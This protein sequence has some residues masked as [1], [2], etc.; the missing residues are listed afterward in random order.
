VPRYEGRLELTWTNK[1]QCLLAHDD[2][3]Y[4]WLSP[5]DYRV[6]EVL[7]LDDVQAVG[8][9]GRRRAADNLL[10]EGDALHALTALAKIPEFRKEYWGKVK[11]AYIDPPFNTQRSW[12]HYDD[13]LEHSVWLAM[14]RDRLGQIKN[15]LSQD[16]SVYVHCDASES[17]YLKAVMDEVFGRSNF[18]TEIIWKRT[19][20]HSDAKTWS[21]VT[22]SIFFYSMSAVI[23]W[24]PP[25]TEHSDEYVDSKY[26]SV[27]DDGRRY[28]LD[29]LTSPNPRPNM[30]YEWKGFAPPAFGWRYA[31]ETMTKLDAEGR[32][33]YPDVKTKRPRLK[34]YL[35]ES[36][37]RLSDNLW[38]DISP[39]N[40]QAKEDS[41]YAT[42]KPEKLLQ[43]IISASSNEGDIVLDCFLGSGT[44]AAVAQKMGRRWIGIEQLAQSLHDHTIPRLTRVIDGTDQSGISKDVSWKGGGGFRVLQVA[45]SMFEAD[46]GMV[47]LSDA[48]TNGRLAEATAAQLGFDYEVEPPFV[49]RKGRARLAVIDGVV[50]EGVIKLLVVALSEGERAV[51]CGTGIDPDARGLLK[52]LAPGSTLRKIPA[53]LLDRYRTSESTARRARATEA[54]TEPQS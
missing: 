44:T 39:I 5:S 47:F 52:E 18:R 34:R 48:M 9:V 35:D 14:M 33:W 29:N 24:N 6:A 20:A 23:T 3:S 36:K 21:Q 15:L 27:D 2:G 42:Q 31:I 7:L 4:E 28:Q 30:M 37:G 10:I 25:Y 51:V 50:N 41:G 19:T 13:A 38:T 17:H 49:G 46:G 53:A 40:S 32:I 26:R 12:L 43:R 22:D 16:G 11:L 45:P 1:D 8:D 54:R